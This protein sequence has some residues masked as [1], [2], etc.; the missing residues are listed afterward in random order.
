MALQIGLGNAN[1][2][3]AGVMELVDLAARHGF[4]T[5]SVRPLA[6]TRA[7]ESGVTEQQL[8]RY[9]KDAG[10][11]PTVLDGHTAIPP[12]I[13]LEEVRG[14]AVP[15]SVPND[16]FAPADEATCLRYAEVLEIPVI[17]VLHYRA[18]D[19]PFDT[20]REVVSG[21]CRRAQKHG[22]RISLEFVPNLGLPNIAAAQAVFTACN[23]PNCAITLD[24]F[25]LDRSGGTLEDVRRLPRNCIANIQVSDRKPQPPGTPHKPMSGRE[26]PGEGKLPLRE[27]M[28]AALANSPAATI[29]I[30]V[31]SEDLRA[32]PMDEA[33]ARLAAGAKFCAA[34]IL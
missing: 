20:L 8:R 32:L 21:L 31:L 26:I 10:V 12:G 25:H 1:F 27:L 34:I 19:V 24:F 33:A 23:E 28:T 9:F 2:M 4:P 18:A 29:D 11:R 14:A 3:Q 22:V 15:K 6:V 16:A 13:Q 5:I 30:E 7:L 17:N